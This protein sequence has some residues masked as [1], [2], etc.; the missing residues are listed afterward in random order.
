M[1]TED[2]ITALRNQPIKDAA[3]P[4]HE[5]I[6][7]YGGQALLDAEGFDV[8]RCWRCDDPICHGWR[9]VRREVTR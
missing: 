9:V 4:K 5:W 1:T 6:E 2:R 8:V 3:M 7:M